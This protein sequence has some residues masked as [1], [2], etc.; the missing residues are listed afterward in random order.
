MVLRFLESH[1]IWDIFHNYLNI[2]YMISAFL[3][4]LC[5]MIISYGCTLIM[6]KISF[7]KRLVS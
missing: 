3:V 1:K 6:Q 4:S 2:N 5:V 7:F